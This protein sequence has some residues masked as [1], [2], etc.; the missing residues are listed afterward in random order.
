MIDL[1]PCTRSRMVPTPQVCHCGACERNYAAAPAISFPVAHDRSLRRSL[2]KW[3]GLAAIDSVCHG[4]S[5]PLPNTASTTA[6]HGTETLTVAD[7]LP[8]KV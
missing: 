1:T 4:D 2:R 5:K 7:E 3:G 8:F 6:A